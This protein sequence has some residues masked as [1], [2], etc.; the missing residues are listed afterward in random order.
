MN[1]RRPGCGGSIV[2]GWCNDCGLA[3]SRNRAEPQPSPWAAPI[4]APST[5][6]TATTSTSAVGRRARFGGA[7]VDL[8]AVPTRDPEQAVMT[9][10]HVPE[11][12]RFCSRCDQRVGRSRDGRPGCTSGFC[13]NCGT[14][15]SFAPSLTG[16]DLV[17][18][19][20]EVVGC[21]AYGGLGWIYLARDRKVSDRWVVLKGLLDAHDEQAVAVA[22]AERGFLAQVEHPNIVQI[23]NFVEHDGAGY[24]VMEFVNGESL[25]QVLERRREANGGVPDPLPATQAIA[26]CLAVLPAI[27]HLHEL[28][29]AYCDLKPDNIMVTSST[30][31]LIDLG[32][33]YRLDDR[34][35]PMYG[36]V[37]YQAPEVGTTGPTVGS[38]LYTVG[39]TLLALCV[40]VPGL[41]GAKRYELPDGAPLL[42]RHGALRRFLRRATA[43]EPADRFASADEMAAQLVGVLRQVTA[44]ETGR[45][46]PGPSSVFTAPR[47][48]GAAGVDRR[49]L[50]TPLVDPEDPAA[51]VIVSLAGV[52][53]DEVARQRDAAPAPSVELDLWLAQALIDAGRG[54][55][56][57]VV[58]DDVADRAPREW[59]VAWSRAMA[60]LDVADPATAA[61]AL[62]RVVDLVP[63]ELAPAV[64]LG[65]ALEQAGDPTAAA[66]WYDV[67]SRTDPDMTA[68][69]FGLARCCAAAGDRAGAIA[70]CDRVLDTS[71]AHVDAQTTK[72]E[73][74]LGDPAGPTL[75]EVV[76]AAGIVERLEVPPARRN[77]LAASVLEAAIRIT[78]TWSA[79]PVSVLGRPFV[80][81]DLRLG[82]EATYRSLARTAASPSE[83]VALVD[84]ANAV[85]PRSWW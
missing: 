17:A 66:A 14:P 63:G 9:D 21:L 10:P 30:T 48:T 69:T 67:A 78:P 52:G 27:G 13:T 83:R 4:P 6:V 12:R 33:V 43:H 39:R 37:G 29:L 16:G 85:R 38:D 49:A 22:V 15:F 31:K 45:P 73:L 41:Q 54:D 71:A 80:E 34:V 11:H 25:R 62:A 68:A 24:I 75:D 32:G 1:C 20:Y 23:H 74:L 42:T 19:Q 72:I 50:P 61:P 36:T 77:A 70:A 7:V 82:L 35:S 28:G 59:R 2:D 57:A 60:A 40:D 65:M 47:R 18:G 55:D 79:P 58:L 76:A 81:R 51:A 53:P 44:A 5:A 8:P 64:A 26:A 84:R 56:A 46:A 3:P